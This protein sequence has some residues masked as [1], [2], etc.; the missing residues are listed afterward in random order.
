MAVEKKKK[1]QGNPRIKK[2][3]SP[4]SQHFVDN[5]VMLEEIKKSKAR[6]AEKPEL[7]QAA[8]TREL[9]NMLILMVDRYATKGNWSGYSYLEDMKSDAKLNLY[10]KW[11]RFDEERYDNPFAFYTQVIYHC[12]IGTLTKEKKQRKIRDAMIESL[13]RLPSF[14]RQQEH[15]DEMREL[16]AVDAQEANDAE[17]HEG[18]GPPREGQAED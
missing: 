17:Q 9:M 12:F 13:G 6:L 1:G 11:H 14:T 4:K 18:E 3:P 16:E 8:V 7:G 10:M 2:P 15:A 5:V